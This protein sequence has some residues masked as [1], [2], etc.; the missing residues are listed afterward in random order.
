MAK[1]RPPLLLLGRFHFYIMD[2]ILVIHDIYFRLIKATG[3]WEHRGMR[4]GRF[5]RYLMRYFSRCTKDLKCWWTNI[6]D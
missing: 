5:G 4:W 3:G 1:S 6:L 2:P